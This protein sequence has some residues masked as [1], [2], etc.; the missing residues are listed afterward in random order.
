M[1][2]DIYSDYPNGFM[3]EYPAFAARFFA[4]CPWEHNRYYFQGDKGH[5]CYDYKLGIYD[6][7]GKLLI[8]GKREEL[9]GYSFPDIPQNI[10]SIIDSKKYSVKLMGIWLNYGVYNVRLLTDKEK[11][12]GT[13][14]S[15]VVP[16]PD[17]KLNLDNVEFIDIEKQKKE[18]QE[19]I[20]R[21]EKILAEKTKVFN[22]INPYIYEYEK[23]KTSAQYKMMETMNNIGVGL[24]QLDNYKV[25]NVIKKSLAQKA[26]IDTNCVL[27]AINNIPINELQ[28]KADSLF[29]EIEQLEAEAN[30]YHQNDYHD[31]EK[32]AE[33]SN[34]LIE[35]IIDLRD[36]FIISVDGNY[37]IDNMPSGTTL[38][39]E[40]KAKGKTTQIEITVP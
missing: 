19:R 26:K 17:I 1:T 21:Q 35:K 9:G 40:K 34:T 13:I 20:E 12:D 2:N 8:E 5:K 16:L 31:I 25:I 4:T 36:G 39:F 14:R 33:I 6:E 24:D 32:L 10:M 23:R 28:N 30:L 29:Q 22:E 7:N 11:K 37:Y 18:E 3:A 15:V 38:Q 27:V